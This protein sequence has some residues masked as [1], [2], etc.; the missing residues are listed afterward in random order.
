MYRYDCLKII[1]SR[2]KDELC[3]VG[4]GGLVDEWTE[5]YPANRSLPLNAMGC[6]VP[7]ALGVA[8]GLPHRRIV[9]LDGEGSLL[10]NLGA[11]ATLG[12]ENPPNLLTVV[13]DN[14]SYESSGG[15]GTHTQEGAVDLAAMARGAGIDRARSVAA[16]P[17]FEEALDEAL[18]RNEQAFLVARVDQGTRLSPQRETDGIED[19]Y[20]FVR[21]IERLES[22]RVLP[23]LPR[24]KYDVELP[25]A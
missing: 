1:A 11:L 25:S 23:L 6:V 12:N 4:L 15:F 20:N 24:K 17:E 14:G 21:T 18:A 10:M 9:A 16:P 19:K 22:T 8:V 3:I 13:F 5:I 7:L 2:L